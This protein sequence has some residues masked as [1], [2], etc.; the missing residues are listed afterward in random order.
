MGE[1]LKITS[2]DY[3][4]LF[5]GKT[6]PI[7]GAFQFVPTPFLDA[8]KNGGIIA[9][10]EI[11][12]SDP[13]VLMGA[14]GQA[15][16]KPFIL[17]EDGYIP[18]RRH[19]LCVIV[20][21]MNQGANGSRAPSEAF[22]RRCPDVCLIDDPQE[23]DFISILSKKG[24][25]KRDCKMVYDTYKKIISWLESSTVHEDEVAYSLTMSHCLSALRQMSLGNSLNTAIFNTMI[26][27]IGIKDLSLA[28]K[29]NKE[30]V[31]LRSAA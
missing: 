14:T 10:E 20:A 3:L 1:N 24:Y 28:R 27:A 13:G 5:E 30:V 29:V 9:L 7:K 12:L 8:Y 23:K 26:G 2:K 25:D 19:P 22:T 18:V 6:K 11:N 17:Y 21:T 31:E 16:E 15:I 4:S